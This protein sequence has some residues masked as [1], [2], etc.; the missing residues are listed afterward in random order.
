MDKFIKKLR[1]LNIYVDVKKKTE[2]TSINRAASL[3]SVLANCNKNQRAPLFGYYY[4]HSNL[5]LLCYG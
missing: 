4:L 2:L 3:Y 5:F 1:S